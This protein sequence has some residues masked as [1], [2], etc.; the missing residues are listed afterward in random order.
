MKH[1]L[2]DGS[3]L[4]I[5]NQIDTATGTVRLKAVFQ[6]KNNELYPNQFV[7]ARLLI[8]VNNGALV[9]PASAV[10]NGPQGTFVYVVQ[11][12]KTALVKP[13]DVG[14]IHENL[15]SIKSGLTIGELVVIDGADR[16]REGA[17][18][19]V[20]QQDDSPVQK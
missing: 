13:V 18:V 17:S 2:A 8:G 11:N 7:N 1:K 19:D 16:L 6:N 15:A 3:L 5:D 10:Q 20:K 14:E 4:T 9:V 12:D